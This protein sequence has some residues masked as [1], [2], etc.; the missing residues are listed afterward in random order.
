MLAV[1]VAVAFSPALRAPFIYDDLESIA[2]NVTI[3]RL[4]P[5]TVP[6]TPPADVATTGRPVANLSLALNYAANAVAGVDQAPGASDPNQTT[7][8]HFANL[9]LHLLAGALLFGVVRRTMQ[10]PRLDERW[11]AIADPVATAVTAVWLLHPLQTEAVLYLTQRTELLVSVCYL[12]TLY[13]AI[14]AWDI[15]DPVRRRRWYVAA[16]A[17]CLAGMGSKEVMIS[18][19]LMVLLYERAF[20]FD[21]WR[22]TLTLRGERRAFHVALWATTLWLLWFILMG[23]RAETVGFGLGLP[24]YRYL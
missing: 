13:G 15:P 3:R 6:L 14:R 22:E 17:A 7:G 10:A 18:A 11:R 16:V 24:W 12:A 19:P 23:A 9:L 5:L 4:W 2:G 8:Y 21:S 1:A 20:R